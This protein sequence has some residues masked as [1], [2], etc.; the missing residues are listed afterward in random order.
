MNKYK[1][2]ILNTLI[3]GLGTFSSKVLVFLLMPL[4]TRVLT[5]ADYGT[6]DLI[7]QTGNLLVPLVMMGIFQCG[8]PLWAG[9]KHQQK[10]CVYHGAF[11]GGRRVCGTAGVLPAYY[12]H[13]RFGRIRFA[14]LRLCAYELP[15]SICSNFVRAKQ[16]VRL[17]AFDGFLSTLMTVTFNILFLVVFKMGITGYVLA[18]VLADFLS[19]VFLFLVATS[20]SILI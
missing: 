13:S 20:S 17:Y 10:R 15:R 3:F 2:L 7:M 1:N 19:S 18:T 4:Y 12:A 8:Y 5:S 16:Y 14:Y 11:V 9:Q 6:V